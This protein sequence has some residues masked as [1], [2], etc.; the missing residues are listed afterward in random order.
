MPVQA[1]RIDAVVL[2]NL[3]AWLAGREPP[4]DLGA[5]DMLTGAAFSGH[6]T[7]YYFYSL[8]PERSDQRRNNPRDP[9]SCEVLTD[10]SQPPLTPEV[11]LSA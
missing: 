2:R 9:P 4:I 3:I 7:H 5:S 10:R 1:R 6:V 11:M 8:Q